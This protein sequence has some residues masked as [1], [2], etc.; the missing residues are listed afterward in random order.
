MA[1][2]TQTRAA[3]P[4]D[5]VLNLQSRAWLLLIFAGVLLVVFVVA[6]SV[7]SVSIPLSQVIAVLA[8]GEPDRAT[9]ATIIFRHRLPRAITATL[10]GAGLGI[11][12]LLMQ[13]F[14]RNPLAGPFVLGISS[15]ASLGVAL[16][17]LGGGSVGAAMIA[18][19]GFSRDLLLAAAAGLGAAGTMVIIMIAAHYVDSR[20][21]LLILGLMIGYLTGAA[22]SLLLHFSLAERIQAYVNWTFGSFNS[23]TWRQLRI[24]APAII[25]GSGIAFLLAKPLNALLLGEQY[26]VSLGVNLTRSRR[27]II[28]ATALLA[29]AVTAFCGPVGFIGVAVPHLCRSILNTSDHRV[30]LPGVAIVGATM[31]L[32]AAIIAEAPGS[33][34]VLP[35]NA[36]TAVLGAPVVIRV[37]LARGNA[38]KVFG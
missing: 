33:N 9:W 29:G 4:V 21:T 17:V 10:A 11:S 7:G 25:A 14:F 18:G 23:V 5:A 31:A 35:L 3:L 16:V 34:I 15:G 27:W 6:L 28:T 22:V 8:G 20:M 32:T 1:S 2:R 19:V 37:I 13:T 26:A 38:G 12:G 24:L 36:I 30:L